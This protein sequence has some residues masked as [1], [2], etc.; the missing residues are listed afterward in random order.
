MLERVIIRTHFIN[1]SA[2]RFDQKGAGK[3][4]MI[5]GTA[6]FAEAACGLLYLLLRPGVHLE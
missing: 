3:G 4:K 1:V 6:H 2:M 5:A